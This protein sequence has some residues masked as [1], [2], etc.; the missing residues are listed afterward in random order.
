MSYSKEETAS[1]SVRI[2]MF[3]ATF[4]V[5]MN[6]LLVACSVGLDAAVRYG[7][8][9]FGLAR[10]LSNYYEVGC[11][12]I[13]L[14]VS[15][16]I[17]YLFN[18]VLWTGSAIVVEAKS[19]AAFDAAAWMIESLWTLLA[20]VFA[21]LFISYALIK[22]RK[23][24]RYT[25]RFTNSS[26]ESVLGTTASIRGRVCVSLFYIVAFV[27]LS[28][29]RVLFRVTGSQSI[30]L[31]RMSSICDSLRAEFTLVV[32]VVDLLVNVNQR[33]VWLGSSPSHSHSPSLSPT[34]SVETISHKSGHV[35]AEY[36][37]TNRN[38]VRLSDSKT[39]IWH[40]SADAAAVI[41]V[42]GSRTSANGH[43]T[44]AQNMDGWVE[45]IDRCHLQSSISHC[46]NDGYSVSDISVESGLAE[47]G[48]G[49]M[50]L[51]PLTK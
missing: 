26:M 15:H 5:V 48:A 9:S 22:A 19:R 43:A 51:Y 31:L 38:F 41:K 13:A 50:V 42:D 44:T 46:E 29:W 6:A 47:H 45:K 39:S 8:R 49:P 14:L 34:C 7:L 33:Q 30:W 37:L 16:P 1:M 4:S 23:I 40:K 36:Q 24:A 12:A 17:L 3:I 21:V 28:V 25:G 32:F 11:F 35:L 10:R 20:I 2:S 27:G 18:S